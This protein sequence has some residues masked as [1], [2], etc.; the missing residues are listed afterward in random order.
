VSGCV[1]YISNKVCMDEETARRDWFDWRLLCYG[2]AGVLILFVPITV[3]GSHIIGSLYLL[4]AGPI[5]SLALLVVAI[6]TKGQ[7]RLALLST[8]VAYWAISWGL[9]KNSLELRTATRWLLWSKD[10]KTKVLTQP[11]SAN[12]ALKHIEWDGWG[13]PGAGDTVVYLVFDPTD[14]LSTE[15]KGHAPGHFSGIPC[16]VLRVRRLESHYYSVLFYTETDWDHCN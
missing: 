13:F 14:S 10:Y 3:Y 8:L 2:A 1:S 4:V 16:E 7:R 5:I 6:R 12:G 15:V 9:F 11:D